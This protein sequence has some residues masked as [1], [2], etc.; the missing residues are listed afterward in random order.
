VAGVF[1]RREVPWERARGR[2]LKVAPADLALR[3]PVVVGP[4]AE[5]LHDTHTY[6]MAPEAIGIAGTLWLYRDRVRITAGR[7][8]SRHTRLWERGAK[9]TLPEHRAEHVAAVS[10]KRAKRY[11]Q[12]E[13]LLALGRPALDYL[14]ELTHR[15][16]RIW[17][18]DVDRLHG[19]LATYGDNA[20][21]TALTRG[22]SEQA[23][24]AEYIAHYLA[25]MVTTPPTLPLG[26]PATSAAPAPRGGRVQATGGARRTGAPRWVGTRR[27]PGL[28]FD[29][30]GGPR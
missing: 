23:I 18:R 7:F 24:G 30:D 29:P 12:R 16:P 6:S 19:L 9:S 25:E 5:V 8:E 27:S 22:L 21:R 1:Q 14:T 4:T 28:P 17:I 13:H 26:P 3:V 11:L 15:R 2:P 10:G 20:L